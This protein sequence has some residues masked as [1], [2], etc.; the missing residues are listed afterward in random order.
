MTM[1]TLLSDIS[2]VIIEKV[3]GPPQ[4]DLL[5]HVFRGWCSWRCLLL[6]VT[7][8][9]VSWEEWAVTR[10]CQM[11]VR[12]AELL[13]CDPQ[14]VEELSCMSGICHV[15]EQVTLDRVFRSKNCPLTV[16]QNMTEHD[17]V[18]VV[19]IDVWFR[20][21]K[22]NSSLT[23]HWRRISLTDTSDRAHKVSRWITATIAALDLCRKPGRPKGK[24]FQPWAQQAVSPW[25]EL[26]EVVRENYTYYH[27]HIASYG[28]HD[29]F[30]L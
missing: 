5:F 21:P 19:K 7:I 27:Y 15:M 18:F 1:M 23:T 30:I 6:V 10:V 28:H 13:Q 8:C 4:N 11:L 22:K 25:G 20:G 3:M 2:D 24:T 12:L 26:V 14:K 16:Q 29:W 17:P 9:A